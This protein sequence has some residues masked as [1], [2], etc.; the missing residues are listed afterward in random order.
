MADKVVRQLGGIDLLL[1]NAAGK[2]SDLEAF[3]APF[4]DYT[5]AQWR[6]IMAVNLDGMF[7]V[8]QAVGKQ[9]IA[10]QTGGTMVFTSSIYGMLAPDDRI[11]EGSQY[12]GHTINTPAVYAASK[13]A[14]TGLANYLAARWAKHRI[15]VNTLTPGGVESGQNSQFIHNDSQ[16][17]PLQRMAHPSEMAGAAVFLASDA[18]SYVTG[19]NLVVDGGLHVW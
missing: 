6:E 19:H 7:L 10:Q 4:E 11:Y 15:R 12:L 16:R 2:S 9:M 18:A 1:N 14:V 17:V 3:F 8:S 5:L 13:S